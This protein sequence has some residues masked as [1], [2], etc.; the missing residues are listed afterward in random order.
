MNFRI[1]R[2]TAALVQPMAT[3]LR[4]VRRR[5]WFVASVLALALLGLMYRAYSVAVVNHDF[6]AE[7][8]N[9]QQLRTYKVRASRG[10]IVDRRHIALAV[11]DRVFKIVLNPRLIQAQGLADEVMAKVLELFPDEDPQ[12][13]QEELARDKAY[14][15]LRMQLDDRQAEAILD[16]ELPGVQLERIP[17]RVYPRKLLAAHVLGRVSAQGRGNLGIEYGLDEMLRGRDAMS[18]AYIARGK[19]LLVDGFP[20]PGVSRGHTIVL[21]IDSAIQSIVEEEINTLVAEWQ[22][23]SASVVVLDPRN[24]E[25]LAM[26][27][28]PTFDPNHKIDKLEQTVN[29]VVQG[30]FE[31]GSTMKAITVAAALEQ[32]VVRQDESFFC[33]KGRWQYTEDHAIRDTHHD[34]WLSV[35]EILAVSSNICTTKIYERLDKQNLYKWVKRFHFGE[36]PPIELP[37]ATTGV[38][39]PWDKWSD[40]Q[41]ANISFGQ[42]MTASPLQVASAFAALANEGMYNPPTIVRRVL[43]VDGNE[44]PRDVREPERLVRIATARTVM[45]MLENVVHS[46]QGTGRNA[47][48]V[49][50]R[51]AGKTSTAQKASKQGGYAEDEYFASFVGAVPASRPRVVILVSVDNPQREHFGN[52]V[53]APTFSRI[54]ARVMEHLGV[55]REDGTRPSPDPIAL[56]MDN[57]K[58]VDGFTPVAD[59]EP[60]LPGHRPIAVGGGLPDFTG[61]T[62]AEALDAAD[63]AEVLLSAVGTGIAVMQNLPPG[64]VDRGA[65]ITVYFEP[66]A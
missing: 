28:R 32:G 42:G 51:V 1:S 13:L 36:R 4:S 29:Q 65:R 7:Q 17:D 47:Q 54:G 34:G 15:A 38:L 53:A 6:Y 2:K 37:G 3:D 39:E 9:R 21:T 60:D 23:V 56:M 11:S 44:V 8:G 19:R 66:P 20:D 58:L 64:P 18:P 59:V 41:G 55:E 52:K 33:E 25:V 49:G 48:I 16:A 26:A 14:R 46:Q 62:L 61:L 30:D 45:Q 5:A 35:A 10:D 27:S 31:P 22:P 63:E 12:Y 50:Y 24:G 40:I 43:D 57:T